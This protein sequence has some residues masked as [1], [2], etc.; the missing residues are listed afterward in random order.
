MPES[1]PLY[2]DR[3]RKFFQKLDYENVRRSGGQVTYFSLNR[4]QNVDPLYNEPKG[5]R[6]TKFCLESAHIE[7]QEIDGRD[8]SVR[9]EGKETTQTA[10]LFISIIEWEKRAPIDPR[11]T[12]DG[13]AMQRR[14]KEGDVLEIQR[15]VWNVVQANSGGNVVDRPSFTGYGL[16]LRK[17]LKFIAQRQVEPIQTSVY[18]P[19]EPD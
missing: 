17:R 12:R 15:E 9:D 10:K 1:R 18:G 7:Y 19:D 14:P 11:V 2:G 3:D 6:Y 5:W 4:G 8:V 13:N 16:E